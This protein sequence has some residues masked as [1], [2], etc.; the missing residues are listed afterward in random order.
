MK[1]IVCFFV[2]VSGICTGLSQKPAQRITTDTMMQTRKEM[3]KTGK[4]DSLVETPEPSARLYPNPAV[5]RVEIAIKGF[6]P[7]FVQVLITGQMG[8][9]EREEERMVL[10]GDEIIHMMFSLKPGI[11]YLV[12][13]QGKK[14]A[15]SKLVIQ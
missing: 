3:E 1:K 5:N 6:E 11:Y 12:V 13:K 9:T 14:L 4:Q 8:K 7:G 2:T 10:R 15:R